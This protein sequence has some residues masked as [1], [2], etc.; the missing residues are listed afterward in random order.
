MNTARHSTGN[1]ARMKISRLTALAVLLILA[2]CDGDGILRPPPTTLYAFNAA[3]NIENVFLLREEQL[4]ATMNYGDGTRVSFDSGQYD[5]H[6]EIQP[7]LPTA[8]ARVYSESLTL[9]AEQEHIFVTIA[10]GGAPEIMSFAIDKPPE[11]LAAVRWA[12]VHAFEGLG[13]LDVYVEASGTDLSGATAR[14]TLSFG[15]EALVFNFDIAGPHLYLTS[16]GN[17]TDIIFESTTQV[18]LPGTD[19]VL[20]ISD[21]GNQGT[22]DIMV[23][24][25]RANTLRFGE[26]GQGSQLR[27][28]NA[29]EDRTDRDVY[30]TDTTQAPL[31]GA[32]AF[33][34]LSDYLPVEIATYDIITTPVGNPGTEEGSVSWF[35]T[36]GRY[37][38][39]ILTGSAA[40]GITHT[41]L[42]ED[43]RSISGQS[44]VRLLNAATLFT[45]VLL[46]ITAPGTDITET[47][48]RIEIGAPATAQRLP[49]LPGEY[50]LYVADAF[51]RAVLA[52]PLPVTLADGGVY[53]ILLLNA[54]GGS[55]IDIALFDDFTP[56]PVP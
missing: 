51:T 9:S 37:T 19:E 8:Q 40:D 35:A 55:T 32:L 13:P 22:L 20:V 39:A 23:S 52:G 16:A 42:Q 33:G 6:L 50:E 1:I 38:T 34:L 48:P 17:P 29:T 47:N 28:V 26:V 31:F 24:R 15:G 7:L 3:S 41:V 21:P 27:I 43:K 5:F 18:L 36:P 45:R 2:G 11:D 12:I 46:Y 54:E 56:P 49:V 25:V 14:G 10:P 4:E 30:L 44:T 53:G